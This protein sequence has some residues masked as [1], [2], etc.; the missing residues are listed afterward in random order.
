MINLFLRATELLSQKQ[1]IYCRLTY[2]DD[3]ISL[4]AIISGDRSLETVSAFDELLFVSSCL[5]GSLSI[6]VVNQK[7]VQVLLIV[8]YPNCALDSR[9][10]VHCRSSVLQLAFTHLAYLA[11]LSVSTFCDPAIPL[12]TDDLEQIHSSD[13][14]L[15]IASNQSTPKDV[16]A[17]LDLSTSPGQ[18]RDAIETVL[19]GKTW[20]IEPQEPQLSD[21]EQEI[22]TR[23]AQGMRDREIAHELHISESTI[24]FHMNNV[25][26]KLRAKTRGV[27]ERCYEFAPQPPILGDFKSSEVPQNGGFRGLP[28][29]QRL[30]DSY[31]YSATPDS[32]PGALSSRGQSMDLETA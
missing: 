31:L 1:C 23:L 4:E 28:R 29:V 32:L 21:R 7:A 26:T 8:P 11:G 27:A 16:K 12:L 13:C 14:V 6:H 20:G 24:K 3:R 19:Q 10:R 5:G 18:L 25:L 15:W 9:V 2:G 17:N 30:N 22:M